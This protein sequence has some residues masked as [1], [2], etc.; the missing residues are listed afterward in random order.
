MKRIAALIISTVIAGLTCAATAAKADVE[1]FTQALAYVKQYAAEHVTDQEL[2]EN[3]IAGMLKGIDAHSD[4]LNAKRYASLMDNT[5]GEFPGLGIEIMAEH[6]LIKVITPL[7][8]SPAK[9]AGL[10]AGDYITELNGKSVKHMTL[11][12]AIRTMRGPTGTRIT[13]S[14]LRNNHPLTLTVTRAI[15]HVNS[16]TH[17]LLKDDVGYIR[18]SQFQDN[19]GQAL[20]HA[21]TALNTEAGRPIQGLV[22]DLRNNPGG[23]LK[24]AV[25][26]SDAFLHSDV[27]DSHDDLI[28]STRGRAAGSHMKAHATAGDVLNGA[29]L[30]VLINKGSASASEIVAGAMQDHKRA[31][32]I[33]EKSFGKGSVQT[34]LPLDKGRALKLTTSLYYTPTGRSIQKTGITPDILIEELPIDKTTQAVVLQPTEDHPSDSK[35]TAITAAQ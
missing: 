34:V 35:D 18:I 16:V 13:L 25:S 15:I 28:V 12:T 29:P 20:R 33:G 17:R 22:L 21:I 10:K 6:G 2:L 32:L 26:V 9:K 27:I 30:I 11:D 7:D 23:L 1:R 3:A 8:G 19:T 24:A 4:Y 5:Q 31:T 14:L